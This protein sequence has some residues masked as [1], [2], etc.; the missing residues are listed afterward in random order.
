MAPS[1]ADVDRGGRQH[2]HP[3]R[4]RPARAHESLICVTHLTHESPYRDG[5]S[6][7][8]CTPAPADDR[9]L[10]LVQAR[11]AHQLAQPVRERAE[12]RVVP[13]APP[14]SEPVATITETN[15]SR[16][17]A[18]LTTPF[19]IAHNWNEVAQKYARLSCLFA[20]GD[21]SES[22][23]SVS[24]GRRERQ[25][26]RR[27]GTRTSSTQRRG[28][29]SRQDHRRGSPSAGRERRHQHPRDRREG[30]PGTWHRAPTLP[31]PRGAHGRCAPAGARRRRLRR[32][33]LPAPTGR[34]SERQ[35]HTAVDRRCPQQS[36]PVPARRADSRRSST[37]ARDLLRRHLR[38]RPRRSEHA[39]SGRRRDLSRSGHRTGRR[40]P[41]NS[42]RGR[43]RHPG[44]LRGSPARRDRRSAAAPRP[45]DRDTARRRN[46]Q[47]PATRPRQR[48]RDRARTRAP[49]QRSHRHRTPHPT[50]QPRR[51]NPTEPIAPS[52]R[53]PLFNSG[54]T[55]TIE[56]Q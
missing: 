41:R 1:R 55:L 50:D 44:G 36:P 30:G 29:E 5:L 22:K 26:S 7:V 38:R 6:S 23:C 53:P 54:E 56:N 35:Q 31:Y 46:E 32:G 3:F 18:A 51:R 34:A 15:C 40:R 28:T 9:A 11:R 47:R 16:Y 12:R 45:R 17:T 39:A 27:A 21:T 2:F 37:S 42:A 24:S 4:V 20:E 10:R 49:L 48:S 25:S 43:G 14:L 13:A 8:L 33:G 19:T 52:N